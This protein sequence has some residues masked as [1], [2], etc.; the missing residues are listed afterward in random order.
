M[1]RG[2]GGQLSWEG[3]GGGRKVG[4]W[5]PG[6]PRRVNPGDLQEVSRERLRDGEAEP[7]GASRKKRRGARG[8]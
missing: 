6:E 2:Q 5:S 7:P 4:V 8:L 3:A 1:G